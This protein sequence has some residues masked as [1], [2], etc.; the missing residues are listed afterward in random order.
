MVTLVVIIGGSITLFSAQIFQLLDNITA[1]SDKILSV[2]A[3]ATI[4][5]NSN[6]PMVSPLETGEL[7]G[8]L[9]EL[10]RESLGPLVN[11][12]FSG[13]V[14]FLTGLL[15][16]VVF[17]FLILLYSDG[18]VYALSTFYPE[19]HRNQALTMFKS[20]YSV[21]KSYLTG[22]TTIVLILGVVNSIG[23]WII[24]IESPFLFGF[25]AAILAIIPYVGTVLGAAIPIVYAL[26]VYDSI[27]MPVAIA[28]FFWVVQVIE[29]NFLTP[30]IVGGKLQVNALTAILSI[31]IGASV[32]GIAGMI[33]FLPFAAMLKVVAESYVELKPLS[34]LIGDE[35]YTESDNSLS[36]GTS[37]LK[38]LL[39]RI[40]KLFGSKQ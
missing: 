37:A 6:I 27:W 25:L 36:T 16:V 14:A 8:K 33:L 20:V 32:W 3:E 30:K 38:K 13:T 34:L 9:K 39:A 24:G 19:R 2:F 18:L 23:L 21:G 17:T 26:F 29:S 40:T 4:F 11:Q 22:M 31:I 7:L 10:L 15:S 1:F 12:T 28:I 35:I 5:I